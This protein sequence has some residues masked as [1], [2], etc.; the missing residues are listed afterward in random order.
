MVAW[1]RSWLSGLIGAAIFCALASELTP[2]G[3]VRRVQSALCGI[4]M[5]SA[6]LMPLL[7]IDFADYALN[8]A[9]SREETEAVTQ[10]ADEVSRELNRRS[11]ETELEAYILDKAQTL[12]AQV[13]NVSVSVRWST[14]GVWYPVSAELNGEY[15]AGLANLIEGE[16]GISKADQSWRNN[17]GT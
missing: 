3:S 10:R 8:L 9:Q 5:V 15:H 13:Q 16:L 12:G 4:V 2:K 14:E 17:E 1:I 6:L 7:R 11:I